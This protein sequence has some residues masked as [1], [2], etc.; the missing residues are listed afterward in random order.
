MLA[1]ARALMAEPDM[2]LLDEPSAGSGA[3]RAIDLIFEQIEEIN[4]SG[5]RC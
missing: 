4:G 5:S 3:G 1:L 2:L